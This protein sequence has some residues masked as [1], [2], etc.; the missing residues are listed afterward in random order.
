MSKHYQY[1]Y[2]EFSPAPEKPSLIG[3]MWDNKFKSLL[4][5]IGVYSAGAIIGTDR[6]IR[7]VKN[8][9]RS[10]GQGAR[11]G[12]ARAKYELDKRT[13]SRNIQVIHAQPPYTTNNRVISSLDLE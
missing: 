2:D 1:G 10:V 7:G 9:A 5:L 13:A 11:Y 12:A 8:A 6:S 3:A 4:M